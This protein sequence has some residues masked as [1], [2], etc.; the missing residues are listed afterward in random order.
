M[1][2]GQTLFDGLVPSVDALPSK[3][4][5]LNT[6]QM[7]VGLYLTKWVSSGESG[8]QNTSLAW[9]ICSHAE[10]IWIWAKN[11]CHCLIPG[12]I[13]FFNLMFSCLIIKKK[14]KKKKTLYFASLLLPFL[15]YCTF[16][17]LIGYA[18]L[19]LLISEELCI[20]TLKLII[21]ALVV[22]LNLCSAE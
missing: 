3:A 9:N 1:P 18:G 22:D 8:V 7:N 16:S 13:S 12:F 11:S 17:P 15:C 6:G 19:A 21:K 10:Y 2:S 14:L 5:Y 20:R 4:K